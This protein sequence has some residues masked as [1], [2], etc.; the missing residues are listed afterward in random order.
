MSKEK[1]DRKSKKDQVRTPTGERHNGARSC[2]FVSQKG[3]VAPLRPH[4][5]QI[6]A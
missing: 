2:Q 5:S 6:A 1:Q 4:K 3:V